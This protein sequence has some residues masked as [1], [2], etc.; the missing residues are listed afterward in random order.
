MRRKAFGCELIF[1]AIPLLVILAASMVSH[2][3]IGVRHVLPVFPFLIV[4]AGATASL[5]LRSS[6]AG[7]YAVAALLLFLI[8]SS[9]H[10]YPDYL[11]YANEAFGGPAN[12]YKVLGDSNVDWSQQPKEVR[13]YL[14]KHGIKD[15]WLAYSLPF[16]KVMDYY[17]VH[18]RPLPTAM[19]VSFGTSQQPVPRQISGTVIVSAVDASGLLWGPG[20]MNPYERFQQGHPDAMIGNSML[21]YHGTYDLPLLAAESHLGQGAALLQAGNKDAA[22]SELQAALALAPGSAKVQA[23]AG[24]LLLRLGRKAEADAAFAEAMQK[25][26]AHQPEDQSADIARVIAMVKRS[27][28]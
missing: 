18:C 11:P 6:R 5:L 12:A 9:L 16:G 24:G 8:V 21:V 15:C 14:D 23:Q 19:A 10:A 13:T 26:R 27:S 4:L 20:D 22:L 25:A 17:G 2:L 28:L 1:L 3:N 7:A